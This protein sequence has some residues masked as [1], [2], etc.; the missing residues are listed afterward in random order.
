MSEEIQSEM[1]L[2]FAQL[3]EVESQNKEY[4]ILEGQIRDRLQVLV[5]KRDLAKK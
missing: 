4:T 3:K 2:L 1:A 5:F